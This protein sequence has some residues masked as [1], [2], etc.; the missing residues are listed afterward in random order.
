MAS[1]KYN[2]DELKSARSTWSDI[3][4]EALPE[5]KREKFRQ[6]NWL[7]ICILMVYLVVKYTKSRGRSYRCSQTGRSLHNA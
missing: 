5:D 1:K 3:P 7:L 2:L 4:M 6:K